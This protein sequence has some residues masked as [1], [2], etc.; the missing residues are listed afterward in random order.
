MITIKA[1]KDKGDSP[2]PHDPARYRSEWER[3]FVTARRIG[4]G[5]AA[6]KALLDEHTRLW[7]DEFT[8]P[9]REEQRRED[10]AE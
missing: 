8:H 6:Y 4:K 7:S 10:E 2:R 9:A 5:E 3:I 1:F